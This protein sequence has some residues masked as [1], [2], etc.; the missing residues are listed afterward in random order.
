M[1]RNLLADPPK[2]TLQILDENNN[3]VMEGY[4]DGWEVRPTDAPP[5]GE[6]VI[7]QIFFAIAPW[8]PTKVP[9]NPKRGKISLLEGIDQC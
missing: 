7:P 2:L 6:L 3:I 8:I 1:T 9:V 4:H 5:A